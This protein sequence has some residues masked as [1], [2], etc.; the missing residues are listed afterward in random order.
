MINNTAL[1]KDHSYII[2]EVGLIQSK[3]QSSH[4]KHIS[5]YETDFRIVRVK[6]KHIFYV[7]VTYTILFMSANLLTS[8]TANK[9]ITRVFKLTHLICF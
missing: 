9:E 5:T 2:E 8:Y 4:I 1:R 3:R 7:D 6:Q